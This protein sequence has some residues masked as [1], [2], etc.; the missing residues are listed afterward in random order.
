MSIFYF[1]GHSSAL[2]GFATLTPLVVLLITN[3]LVTL[4]QE[5]GFL[6]EGSGESGITD[7]ALLLA[8]SGDEAMIAVRGNGC[9]GEMNARFERVNRE[10][11]LLT[12]TGDGNHCEVLLTED[13]NGLV[14]AIQGP[15]CSDYHG[16][17]CGFSGQFHAPTANGLAPIFD[18]A[19]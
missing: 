14:N 19:G 8:V 15:G 17:I 7:Y 6:L 9:L 12:S 11:W 1:V 2:N 13:G 10:T 3:P 18:L 4:A 16:S 5:R